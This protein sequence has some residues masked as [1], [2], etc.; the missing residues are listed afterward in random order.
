MSN[1]SV[2]EIQREFRRS[3]EAKYI[4]RLHGVLLVLNGLS[5]V[6]AAGILNEP[7]RTVAEWVKRYRQ[8]GLLGLRDAERSG[9]PKLLELREESVLIKALKHS[10]QKFALSGD[11]WTGK[12]VSQ[13]LKREFGIEMTIRNS[14]RML[15]KFEAQ[16]ATK[17]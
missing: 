9:R 4:H 5:S 1:D 6:K 3:D 13:F 8:D 7:Q 16:I 17:R 14:R 15:R 2:T 12:L 11:Q 10:P